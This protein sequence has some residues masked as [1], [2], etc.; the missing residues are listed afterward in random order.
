MAEHMYLVSARQQT[1]PMNSPWLWDVWGEK[2]FSS[3]LEPTTK[4]DKKFR[5]SVMHSWFLGWQPDKNKGPFEK[6]GYVANNEMFW[7]VSV[8]NQNLYPLIILDH[9]KVTALLPFK[10]SIVQYQCF[11]PCLWKEKNRGSVVGPF[12]ELIHGPPRAVARG[13]QISSK[14]IMCLY[15]VTHCNID[16]LVPLPSQH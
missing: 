2:S 7:E 12:T 14:D 11:I 13:Y 10:D 16:K 9:I 4:M 5:D 1:W 15:E 3:L 8:P 6:K